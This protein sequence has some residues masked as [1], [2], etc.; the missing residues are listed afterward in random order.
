M[1]IDMTKIV[2][3]TVG[4]KIFCV[5]CFEKEHSYEDVTESDF[6]EEIPEEHTAYCDG[7][8]CDHSYI[9]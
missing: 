9:G 6:L 3:V 1:I 7:D 8:G 4:S 5:D 2:A